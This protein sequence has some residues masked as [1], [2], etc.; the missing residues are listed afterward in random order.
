MDYLLTLLD[1]PGFGTFSEKHKFLRDRT[2]AIRQDITLQH[3]SIRKDPQAWLI[4]VRLHEEMARFHILSG[5]RLC[6]LE[7][8]EFDPF[9]NTE[10]LRKVL[11][12]LHEFYGDI[13][14]T[15]NRTKQS[16]LQQVP[17]A[18]TILQEALQNEAEFRA[19]QLLTH[20]EDQDVF[21]QSLS[22]P[23]EIFAREEL[24]R[25][26]D[27]VAALHRKDYIRYFGIAQRAPYLMACLM[28]THFTK[29]RQTALQVIAVAFSSREAITMDTLRRWLLL[30]EG[31][32]GQE[33]LQ[34]LVDQ[35]KSIF[36]L[37]I[38]PTTGQIQLEWQSKG[39]TA[40]NISSDIIEGGISIDS[41]TKPVVL[42]NLST[43]PRTCS[44]I[45]NMA[46]DIPLSKIISG[47]SIIP[48]AALL[49]VPS[50]KVCMP[51]RRVDSNQLINLLLQDLI[52]WL[53]HKELYCLI[54]I[55]I[56]AERARRV[57]LRQTIIVR[58]TEHSLDTIL[59]ELVNGVIQETSQKLKGRQE[60][61]QYRHYIIERIS[62][63][64]EE[65][66][67]K[68]LV[69]G[70]CR[71]LV[72]RLARRWPYIPIPCTRNVVS[73]QL[74]TEIDT[75]R[76]SRLKSESTSSPS[77]SP[78]KSLPSLPAPSK[79]TRPSIE[80]NV[81]P[82]RLERALANLKICTIDKVVAQGP[83]AKELECELNRLKQATEE[84]REKSR[85]LDEILNT[86]IKQ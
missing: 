45:E 85:Q 14:Q 57:A 29:V 74:L 46:K 32:R 76:Q 36:R 52:N 11:Q 38:S 58:T 72:A 39:S 44:F 25:A 9:Q 66:I 54:Q 2:R 26:R 41:E 5:H 16:S 12:S 24:K 23:T 18:T 67:I 8:A 35:V 34:Q 22:F 63:R 49:S 3:Q 59:R 56:E 61:Q 51:T 20:A 13:R 77:Q 64:L 55:A 17:H 84:E 70:E 43:R 71:Y 42:S 31:E 81:V 53:T 27:A 10:Q 50:P 86:T 15:L 69:R 37:T 4:A 79:R 30:E 19:F 47:M 21:R 75:T 60:A 40:S 33:E 73:G 6:E 78:S 82:L 48:P 1:T 83:K 65:K 68:D 80:T 62:Q 28:Q 7:F